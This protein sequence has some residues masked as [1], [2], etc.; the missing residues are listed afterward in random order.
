M[1]FDS[2][3]KS[4]ITVRTEELKEK[5][6]KYI[7]KHPELQQLLNDFVSE[8]LLEKPDDPIAFSREYFSKFNPKPEPYYPLAILGP[9]GVGRTTFTDKLISYYPGIFEIPT[10]ITTNP[11]KPESEVVSRE[12][13]MKLVEEGLFMHWSQEEGEL[14]GIKLQTVQEIYSN[15]RISLL[16]I[17]VDSAIKLHNERF[18]FNKIVIM[19]KN[20]KQLEDRLRDR[21]IN[22][23]NILRVRL[24]AALAEI[25][26]AQKF[27]KIFKDFVVNDSIDAAMKDFLHVIHR[28]YERLRPESFKKFYPQPSNNNPLVLVGP[29]GVGKSTLINFLKD[30]WPGV[31]EFSISST[32]RLP[33]VGEQHGIHYYYI[34]REEFMRK[35]DEDEFIEYCEV[36][37]NLY[38]TSKTAIRNI[39]DNGKICL[40]DIDVQGVLKLINSGLEFNR[41]FI[42]PK[43]IKTL[44]E[45]LRGR[46]TDAEDVIR[47]R[48]KN[49]AKEMDLAEKNSVIFKN[50]LINEDLEIAKEHL[51]EF[52]KEFYPKLK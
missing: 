40:L 15:S 11:N 18:E 45:R 8:V 52:V 12:E 4:I 19:P 24:R 35:I 51:F 22:D 30:R 28:C 36:H 29:S 23:D 41:I 27:P 50:V 14:V 44:E 6:F 31:F 33:R 20:M 21:G 32:T 7:E 48:L 34:T 37:N 43:D 9:S 46:A 17:S 49:A 1:D 47:N 3:E 2:K 42:R 5:H 13:F 38:G 39:F 26:S 16:L 25:E 10:I